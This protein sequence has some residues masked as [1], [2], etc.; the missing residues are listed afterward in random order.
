MGWDSLLVLT[1]VTGLTELVAAAPEQRPTFISPDLA[2]LAEP[3]P[4][5]EVG[6]DGARLGGWT[7]R[8]EDGA[9]AVDGDGEPADWWRVV[10]AV[11]WAHLDAEGSP[12]ATDGVAAPE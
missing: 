2:A 10:A 5:P 9:L 4:A 6:D 1:G 11:A 7:A 12:V 8:V 3:Q